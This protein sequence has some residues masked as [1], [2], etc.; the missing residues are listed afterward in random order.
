MEALLRELK[1]KEEDK[2]VCEWEELM[3]E[4]DNKI[5]NQAEA[6]GLLDERKPNSGTVKQLERFMDKYG[7]RN[8]SGWWVK[9]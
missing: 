9:K 5:M 3:N 7:Y 2:V 8:G 4:L 6:E 1:D